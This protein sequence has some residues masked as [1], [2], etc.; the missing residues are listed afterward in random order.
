M[1]QDEVRAHDSAQC[2][3]KETST[4]PS[5]KQ[6]LREF[7]AGPAPMESDA[8]GHMSLMMILVALNDIMKHDTLDYE[9]LPSMQCTAAFSS[10]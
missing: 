9:T 5:H 3:I 8:K 7:L 6:P 2:D 1:A 4:S 10:K